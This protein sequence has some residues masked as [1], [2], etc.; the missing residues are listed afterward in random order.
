MDVG[1][2]L[3]FQG[4]DPSM[5]D[6]YVY[7]N[8]IRLGL[9][10]EELGFQSIWGVEHHF[11]D[12]TMCP[13]VLQFLTYF[14]AKSDKL[15]LGSM[16]VVLPW[17]DPMRVAEE[18]SMLDNLSDGRFIL[19]IGRGLGRVEFEGFG[20]DMNVSREYFTESAQMLLQGLETG[21]CEFNGNL[22]QQKAR[23]IR[24]AP[25]KSFKGRTYAAAVSPESSKIMAELG[26]GILIIPQKPWE[27]VEKELAEYRAIYK[28]VH[29]E[30]AP[31]PILGGWTFCDEDAGR[32]EEMARKY[33]GGYYLTVVQHYEMQGNHFKDTKGYES[34]VTMQEM[35][36]TDVQSMIEFFMSIQV[37]GTPEQCYD[38]IRLFTERTGAGAYNGVFSFAGM[39]YADVEK[40][41]R[42]FSREV[43][44]QVKLLPGKPLI[45]R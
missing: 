23:D 3:I 43:M 37:W 31:A 18:I 5:T 7:D 8:E 41:M 26:V 32:A 25:L 40:S 17:H 22:I 19:G 39:P 35:A 6:K 33:I 10:A 9:M 1:L 44:P 28:E 38:R 14:A 27:H 45:E 11:T 21:T 12:Y 24:P 30:E 36:N 20:R 4:S 15:L 16:V 29:A 34:Y 42:L 2:A 13:D